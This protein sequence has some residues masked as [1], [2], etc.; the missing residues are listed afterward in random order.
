MKQE[1]LNNTNLALYKLN[2]VSV[3]GEESIA[4]MRDSFILLHGIADYLSSLPDDTEPTE[5]TPS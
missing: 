3:R 1:L 5:D 2:N 4:N